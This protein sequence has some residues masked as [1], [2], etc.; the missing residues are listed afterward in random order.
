[1][2]PRFLPALVVKPGFGSIAA[3][4]SSWDS[5]EGPRPAGLRCPSL[6]ALKG[7]FPTATPLHVC[8]SCRHLP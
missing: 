1:M 3:Q 6:V 8:L 7:G 4:L 2:I 5:G